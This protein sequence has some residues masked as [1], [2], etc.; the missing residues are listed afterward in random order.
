MTIRTLVTGG[1]GFIG[2]ELVRLLLTQEQDR[3]ITIVDNLSGTQTDWH[4]LKDQTTIQIRDL[5]TLDPETSRFDEVWHLASPVGS[6]GILGASGHIAGDII[7]LAGHAHEIA[8]ASD[9]SLLY[10]SSSEVYGRDGQHDETADLIVPHRRGARMEYAIGKLGAEHVLA[11]RS[12]DSGVKLHIIRPFNCAGPGQSADM[13]F[14]MPTFVQ[15]ALAGKPLPV[16][17][18]GTARRA[19]CHV[20]DLVAGLVAVQRS[21]EPGEVYNLG[22]AEGALTIADLAQRVVDRLGSTSTIE[23]VDPRIR[24]GRHWLDAF[25]KIPNIAK[26]RSQTGWSPSRT[27][28]NII[29]DVAAHL[30]QDHGRS[31]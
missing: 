29:D 1:L 12:T 30:A 4:D 27:L 2:S 21:G 19:F 8:E 18:D 9:A 22:Q 11:N 3:D 26:V 23:S 7:D 14:V 20:Q 5:R 17:G 31:E 6:L 28:D 15:A 13:G 24:F 25:D 16:H 10:V